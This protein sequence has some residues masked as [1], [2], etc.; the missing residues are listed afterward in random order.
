[1]EPLAGAEKPARQAVQ[2]SVDASRKVPAG[3]AVQA[4]DRLLLT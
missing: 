3:Q 2:T 4:V 1:V